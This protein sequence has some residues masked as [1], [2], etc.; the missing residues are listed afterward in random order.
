MNCSS[1]GSPRKVSRHSPGQKMKLLK[2]ESIKVGGKQILG[3]LKE[4]VE[5][6]F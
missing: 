5:E 1:K 4:T 2:T 6:V 3:G